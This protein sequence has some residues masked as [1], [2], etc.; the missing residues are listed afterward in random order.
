MDGSSAD[1]MAL[2]GQLQALDPKI[3]DTG[4]QGG[5]ADELG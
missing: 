3:P 4:D 2:L 5:A 1:Y